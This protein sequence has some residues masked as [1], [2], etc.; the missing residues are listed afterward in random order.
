MLLPHQNRKASTKTLL[1]VSELDHTFG[2]IC[3]G[4]LS[5]VFFIRGFGKAA[6][7]SHLGLKN[8]LYEY[9]KA[10]RQAP[11]WLGPRVT[12]V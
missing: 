9:Q 8:K 2:R 5:K 7:S 6:W 1:G 11:A 3:I 12:E 10:D 4:V